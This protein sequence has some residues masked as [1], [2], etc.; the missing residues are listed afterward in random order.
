MSTKQPPFIPQPSSGVSF[1]PPYVPNGRI[2][3][4]LRYTLHP[5]PRFQERAWQAKTYMS[6]PLGVRPHPPTY[7]LHECNQLMSGNAIPTCISHGSQPMVGPTKTKHLD[8]SPY[9]RQH[10]PG[11]TLYIPTLDNLMLSPSEK[12][13]LIVCRL[14]QS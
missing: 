13:L 11:P 8:P 9:H 7:Q 4:N 12:H 10:R 5:T 2:A 3:C 14:A 6:L 1:R